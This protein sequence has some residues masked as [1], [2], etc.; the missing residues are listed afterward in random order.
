M[1]SHL[2]SAKR[3]VVF[4]LAC[5]ITAIKSQ[6]HEIFWWCPRVSQIGIILESEAPV[7]AGISEEYAP[8]RTLRAQFVETLPNQGASN[9]TALPVGPDRYRSQPEPSVI[10]AIDRDH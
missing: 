4:N 6:S 1:C 2:L 7:I 5:W 10:F 3:C 8:G 9:A